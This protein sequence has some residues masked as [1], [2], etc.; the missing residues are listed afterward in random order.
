MFQKSVFSQV[1]VTLSLEALTSPFKNVYFEPCF[2]ASR[3]PFQLMH[4]V[5]KT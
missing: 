1:L 4:T 5:L 2:I 3:R